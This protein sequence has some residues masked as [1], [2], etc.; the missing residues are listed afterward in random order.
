[1]IVVDG[2]NMVFG[3][4]ASKIAKELMNDNSVILIN[5]EK[6]IISGDLKVVFARYNTK[7]SLKYKG[8]PEKSPQWPRV[9]QMFVKRIIRGMLPWKKP[10]GKSVYRNLKVYEGVPE[11]L[12]ESP[13]VY[14]D[15]KPKNISKYTTVLKLCKMFG[16]GG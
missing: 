13:K 8:N 6:I 1:M 14:D 9:P 2:T 7:R 3:R 12:K 11:D 15:C 4:I 10:R 5:A 16:Y